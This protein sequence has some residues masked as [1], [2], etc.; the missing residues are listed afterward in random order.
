MDR[1]DP[2]CIPRRQFVQLCA[3]V[4]AGALACVSP[5]LL[6][7]NA[8]TLKPY[9]RAPLLDAFG[10]PIKAADLKVGENYV[11]YY[12]YVSTPCF[13]INLGVPAHPPAD[14]LTEKG[15]SYRWNGGVGPQHAIVAYSAI[16]AHKM[17]HPAKEVSFINYRH[18]P[19]A[20]KRSDGLDTKQ[21]GVIYC[22]SEKSVYDP[23]QGAKVLGGPAKQPLAA[24]HLEHDD[25]TGM[26]Y[27]TGTYG[28]EMFERFFSEFGHRLMLEF[29]T[30][31][32][33][34]EVEKATV[35]P[36]A[37]I[38]RNQILC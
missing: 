28:G 18:A 38:C 2:T 34:A 21:P 14:L 16:C 12:P 25:K 11:F 5:L 27:A 22:C 8:S 1:D 15:A 9:R 6:A 30:K 13:L 7:Q 10:L 31:N 29:R 37:K 24:I 35:M 4:S 36:L 20:F 3:S 17:S 23:A 32:L 19:A 26:L 33:R